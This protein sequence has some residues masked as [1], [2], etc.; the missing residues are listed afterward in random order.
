MPE[1]IP[2]NSLKIIITFK[3]ARNKSQEE[4]KLTRG[5][6]IYAMGQLMDQIH[7]RVMAKLLT[8]DAVPAIKAELRKIA[9]K[10]LWIQPLDPVRLQEWETKWKPP[11]NLKR[12]KDAL[13]KRLKGYYIGR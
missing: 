3:E 4:F 9:D 10:C 2:T 5:T 8:P 6:G 11:Q 12:D 7:P 13:A 1:T